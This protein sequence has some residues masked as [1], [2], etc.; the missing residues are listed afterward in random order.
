[1]DFLQFAKSQW[2]LILGVALAIVVVITDFVTPPSFSEDMIIARS[3]LSSLAKFIVAGLILLLLVPCSIYN[4]KKFQ[5]GWWISSI[6]LFII[7]MFLYFHY[8]R[9]LRQKTAYNEYE[10]RFS[11]IGNNL[12]PLSQRAIDS[13]HK[14]EGI[15]LTPSEMLSSLG[16]PDSIW[17]KKEIEENAEFLVKVYLLTVATFSLFILSGIQASYCSANKNKNGPILKQRTN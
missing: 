1:M 15:L 11:V 17:P 14:K 13:L 10:E 7:A 9:E 2:N 6:C 12:Q 3:N 5:W 8:N 16:P 4:Q